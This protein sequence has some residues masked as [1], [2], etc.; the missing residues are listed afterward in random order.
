MHWF[1]EV[2]AFKA[3]STAVDVLRRP[4]TTVVG[5]RQAGQT[6]GSLSSAKRVLT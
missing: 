2:I 4:V 6:I 5:P 3:G 1:R